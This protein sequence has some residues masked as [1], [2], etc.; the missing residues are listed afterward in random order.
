MKLF[1]LMVDLDPENPNSILD[2]KKRLLK[3]KTGGDAVAQKM[4]NKD[5]LDSK[6]ELQDNPN[7][8]PQIAAADK[9]IIALR[10]QIN[11]LNKRKA[12]LKSQTQSTI[13][14]V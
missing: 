5:F 12:L 8:N 14:G 2:A 1:E 13:P 10:G 3:V 9:K 7:E 11:Q 6:K 4:A